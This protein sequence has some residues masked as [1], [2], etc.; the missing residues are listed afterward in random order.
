[1]TPVSNSR[2]WELNSYLL[3][4]PG[5]FSCQ[6]SPMVIVSHWRGWQ[7][8]VARFTTVGTSAVL[9]WPLKPGDVPSSDGYRVSL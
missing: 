5:Y 2:S 1:M 8:V 6:S 3:F 7:S 9:I 4:E